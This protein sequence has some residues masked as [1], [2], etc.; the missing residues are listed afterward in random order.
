MVLEIE[1]D[2]TVGT[3]KC[4]TFDLTIGDGHKTDIY[5]MYM[6]V[7]EEATDIK[8]M[9]M[10]VTVETEGDTTLE[11]T[12]VMTHMTV[13]IGIGAEQGEKV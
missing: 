3:D 4:K 8:I 13:E 7:G 6:T 12:S 11:G 10:E 1:I 9:I 2:H 5:S